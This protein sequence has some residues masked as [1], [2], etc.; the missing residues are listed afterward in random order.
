MTAPY[1]DAAAAARLASQL[2]DEDGVTMCSFALD[3]SGR[4]LGRDRQALDLAGTMTAL[5]VERLTA[6][7]GPGAGARG[8]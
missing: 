8:A 7:A 6:D 4:V 5:D 1:V 2:P 3:P